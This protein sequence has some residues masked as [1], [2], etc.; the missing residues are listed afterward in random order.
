[1]LQKLIKV[2]DS[3]PNFKVFLQLTKLAPFIEPLLRFQLS[4]FIHHFH[5]AAFTILLIIAFFTNILFPRVISL[6]PN[7]RLVNHRYRSRILNATT[8]CRDIPHPISAEFLV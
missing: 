3:I 4:T 5:L 7:S 1:M 8:L 2:L 6:R